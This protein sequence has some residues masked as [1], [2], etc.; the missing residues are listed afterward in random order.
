MPLSEEQLE[1]RRKENAKLS[2]EAEKQADEARRADLARGIQPGIGG[3]VQKL[4]QAVK[5]KLE[6]NEFKPSVQTHVSRDPA[7]TEAPDA[8]LAT[9]LSP[10]D[11]AAQ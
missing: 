4:A 5:E 9:S 8:P 7:K 10:D 3:G 1:E 6:A 2:D 11:E